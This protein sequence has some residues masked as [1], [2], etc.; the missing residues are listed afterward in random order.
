ME[1]W[2]FEDIPYDT[3][4]PRSI[5]SNPVVPMFMEINPDGSYTPSEVNADDDNDEDYHVE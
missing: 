1:L 5:D 3:Y 4:R 2:P